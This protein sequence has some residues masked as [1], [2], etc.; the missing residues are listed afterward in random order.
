[1]LRLIDPKEY[2]LQERGTAVLIDVRAP[3]EFQKGHCVQAASLPLF[4]DPERVE[5]GTIYKQVSAEEAFLRGLEIVGPKM[6][7]LVIAAREI[8]RGKLIILYCARGGKRSQSLAWLL[9]NAGL[10]VSLIRGGYK[11][12]RQFYHED[13][14]LKPLKLIKLNGRT[15]TGKTDILKSLATLGA[16]IIDLEG[17]AQHRGSA[18]GR[19]KNTVQ[20]STEQFE[21]RLYEHIMSL[22][23]SKD[24]WIEDESRMIGDVAIP[25]TFWSQMVS[26]PK[27]RIERSFDSRLET[28]M[29]HYGELN[30]TYLSDSF[31]RIRKRLGPLNT[32]MAL[33]YLAEGKIREA[34]AIALT[35]Y[36]KSYGTER[37][38]DEIVFIGVIDAN[39]L[40]DLEVAKRALQIAKNQ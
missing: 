12:I 38:K 4:S 9:E 39:Q 8:S 37:T 40:D 20:P 24:I 26:A 30:T 3:S 21:N 34:A 17:L 33:E 35:Y 18:F 6:S 31:S 1:V 16:Q 15:G 19:P 13:L 27:I 2:F 11:A 5:I 32:K 36:D 29:Q 25:D 23:L 22:D 14:G 7:Q 28:I 10:N